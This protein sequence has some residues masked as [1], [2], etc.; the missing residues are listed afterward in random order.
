MRPLSRGPTC[1]P[2][3]FK[4]T[5]DKFDHGTPLEGSDLWTLLILIRYAIMMEEVEYNRI[6]VN[7]GAG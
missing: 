5:W 6:L 2:F 3:G 7:V 1:R 4:V